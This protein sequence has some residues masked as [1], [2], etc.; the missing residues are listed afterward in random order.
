MFIF[1]LV[2]GFNVCGGCASHYSKSTC[3]VNKKC[4]SDI[5]DIYDIII[6]DI[7]L[8]NSWFLSFYN[9]LGFDVEDVP[10]TTPSTRDTVTRNVTHSTSTSIYNIIII[11]IR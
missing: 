6:S 8:S 4:H 9:L 5:N 3:T 1:S 10:R 2:L 11:I 7:I